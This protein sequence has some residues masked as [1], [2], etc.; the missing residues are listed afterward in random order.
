MTR[1]VILGK[2]G[3]GKGTQCVL[4]A[5]HYD[6]PHIST[7]DM[8]RAAVAEGTALGLEAKA[9]MDA[10]NLVSDELILGIV[11][12]RL[13]Q[14]DAE[15]GFLLDG[16]PRTKTQAEGLLELLS[17]NSID[18]AVDIRVPD[19]VVTVRMLERGRTD[20]TP[21]AIARRLELYRAETAPLLDFFEVKCHF[22][23][24]NGLGSESEVQ[25]RIVAEIDGR[26]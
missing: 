17:P 2:Q 26:E 15:K 4:L 18:L 23:A 20:D 14:P 16:F 3:A 11:R 21:E 13:S 1:L 8:L 25:D 12:D 19:D 22:T 6:I 9:V 7:G 5:A 24:V 10:G